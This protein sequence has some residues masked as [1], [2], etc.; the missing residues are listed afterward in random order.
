MNEKENTL[1]T[2]QGWCNLADE[3]ANRF[4]G[5]ELIPHEWLR[6]RFG[7]AELNYE[8]FEDQAEFI[9]ALQEQQFSYMA[10]VEKLRCKLLE[11]MQ[12]CISNVWGDGYKIVPSNDQ[13]RYGYDGFIKDLKKAMREARAI[14]YNVAAV[15][16][17]QQRKDNDLR[18]KF[19]HLAEMI[20]S[21]K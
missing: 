15:D 19:A 8:D 13:A 12:I 16:A 11:E 10:C 14:M 7:I 1:M 18:A 6:K 2:Q 3:I 17:E 20:K 9:K 4:G 21:S 5:G